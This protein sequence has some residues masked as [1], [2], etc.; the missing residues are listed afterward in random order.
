MPVPWDSSTQRKFWNGSAA[1]ILTDYGTKR[2]MLTIPPSLEWD[3]AYLKTPHVLLLYGPLEKASWIMCRSQVVGW[4]WL[5]SLSLHKNQVLLGACQEPNFH[6][7]NALIFGV[8]TSVQDHVW[9][10]ARAWFSDGLKVITDCLELSMA[11]V[12][13]RTDNMIATVHINTLTARVHSAHL[14]EMLAISPAL[15]WSCVHPG[16]TEICK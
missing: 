10:L 8:N 1:F 14:L 2:H 15:Y 13:V 9:E 11:H 12:L 7:Q 4:R 5:K 6:F 16:N 3:L